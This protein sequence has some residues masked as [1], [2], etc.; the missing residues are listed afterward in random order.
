M[1]PVESKF[2]HYEVFSSDVYVVDYTNS[3][4]SLRKLEFHAS[5]PDDIGSFHLINKHKINIYGVNFEK[6]P[7]FTKG[8]KMCECLFTPVTDKKNPWVL[9]LEMKYCQNSDNIDED[10]SN[11]LTQLKESYQYLHDIGLLDCKLHKIH[12]LVSI[13]DYSNKEPF[14][15]FRVSQSEILNNFKNNAI[16]IHG[17][18]RMLVATPYHLFEQKKNY[19][20]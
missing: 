12:L 17:I 10:S 13:P 15:N 9:L 4:N 5:E 16:E 8:H 18:N 6:N 2:A 20:D 1:I 11:A 19:H 14:T 7:A 3:T